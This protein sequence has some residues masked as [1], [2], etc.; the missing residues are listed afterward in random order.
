MRLNL[1]GKLSLLR[2]HDRGTKYGPPTDQ[3]D[4]EVVVQFVGR[5]AD[6][7]GFQLRDDSK[8]PAREGM[9]GLL[10]DG[11]NYGWTV[12]IDYDINAGKKNGTIMRTWLTKPAGV[13][14]VVTGR[15]VKASARSAKRAT[16][17][18][19]DGKKAAKRRARS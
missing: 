12:N 15:G 4:V 11:F 8:G 7:F 3:I 6:A 16:G 5:P 1:S 19:K 10:R 13:P 18:G 14:P 2:V 9:L 17:T